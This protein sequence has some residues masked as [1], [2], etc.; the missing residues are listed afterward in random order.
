MMLYNNII[1]KQ[2]VSCTKEDTVAIVLSTFDIQCLELRWLEME[3]HISSWYI[4]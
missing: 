3:C 4:Y 1:K 2:I